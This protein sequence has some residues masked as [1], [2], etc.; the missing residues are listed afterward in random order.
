MP[1]HHR[2]AIAMLASAGVLA[3][4][5]AMA[6]V[7]PELVDK[8]AAIGRVSDP[9]KTQPL[10]IPMHQ[11]EPYAGVKV[12]RDVKYGPHERNT[13]DLF[14]PEAAGSGRPVFMFVH[15]GGFI[16]G[17]KRAAGS[18]FYDNIMLW[19]VRN[20]MIG[21]NVEYRLA[22][23]SSWPSGGEDLGMAVRW[24]GDNATAHGGDPSRVYLM[25][26]SA[27]ATHVAIYVSHPEFHGPKGSGLAG[28]MF[29]SGA[30]DLTK[31]EDSEGRNE[32]FGADKALYKERSALPG[33]IK[34]SVPF[35]VNA[36]ELDPP[37]MVEQIEMLK[38]AMC[39]SP[40]GCVR[41]L[42]QPK[43]NHMSQ[44]YA[45]NTADTLLSNQMLEFIITGK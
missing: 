7:P 11:K 31:L 22:P 3:C 29:S 41:T 18:P 6:Q 28:A 39:E 33:L 23:Q 5:Q 38:A 32:Y 16:R 25:G 45:I 44:S 1:I 17:T 14:V 10:Y 2:I 36:A 4:S 13:L 8:I 26:H 35:M 27:G 21:V 20:G 12:S 24:A 40:R 15:G 30:Y 43:H 19:A 9:A 37:W 34:T 42:I